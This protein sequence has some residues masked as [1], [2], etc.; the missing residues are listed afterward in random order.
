M[1]YT[2]NDI[3][4]ILD[5][6][7]CLK[8]PKE[9][10]TNPKY[11]YLS[12]MAKV[13]YSAILYKFENSDVENGEIEY[14]IKEIARILTCSKSAAVKYKKELLDTGLISVEIKG[15]N[16]ESDKFRIKLFEGV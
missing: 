1:V 12:S 3:D 11:E 16:G 6:K 15:A 14:K 7:N 2:L 8:L 4:E 9:L 10:F 13:L 5:E